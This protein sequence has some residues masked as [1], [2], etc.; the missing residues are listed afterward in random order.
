MGELPIPETSDFPRRDLGEDTLTRRRR[1]LDEDHP[2][3]LRTASNLAT[4]LSALGQAERARDLAED[5]LTRRRR[6]LGEDHPGTLRAARLL[7]LLEATRDE[8]DIE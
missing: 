1:V 5:T 8:P 4:D 7:E 2:D 6:V 3:T